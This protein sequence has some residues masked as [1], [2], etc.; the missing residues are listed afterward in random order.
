MN[1][2]FEYLGTI[3]TVTFWIFAIRAIFKGTKK[4]V[5]KLQEAKQA[6]STDELKQ[7][8]REKKAKLQQSKLPSSKHEGGLGGSV[9]EH[10]KLKKQILESAKPQKQLGSKD[11]KI[12]SSASQKQP[13]KMVRTKSG[14]N[15]QII[16][17]L[18]LKN[19]SQLQRSV[20]LAEILKPVE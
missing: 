5:S 18:A 12:E 3:F 9:K 15:S 10:Q 1:E 8:L 19:K 4:A 14:S 11:V 20:I 2:L 17:L 16:N 6:V 13:K 7:R